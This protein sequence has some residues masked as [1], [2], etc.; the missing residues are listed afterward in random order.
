MSE[1]H[2][3]D[4][5]S[6]LRYNALQKHNTR[7]NKYDSVEDLL[8][9]KLERSLPLMIRP[10]TIMK[11]IQ[12]V[13]G[14]KRR[15]TSAPTTINNTQNVVQLVLPSVITQKFAT[16]IN[17]QVIKAGDQSLLTMPSSQLLKM[18]TESSNTEAKELPNVPSERSSS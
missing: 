9:E 8:L 1:K 11:A 3:A 15:G 4:K 13:N 17:N 16:D 14:A 12:V 10:D 7:D 6:A 5:V 18:Q 2:F